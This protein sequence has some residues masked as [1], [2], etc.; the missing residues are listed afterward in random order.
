MANVGDVTGDLDDRVSVRLG[1]LAPG[2]DAFD[3]PILESY[4]VTRS[5]LT[6]P[7]TFS[8]R[9]GWGD[10]AR[11]LL[12]VLPPRLPFQLVVNGA[13]Q[14]TGTLDGYEASDGG[15]ATEITIRGRDVMAPLHDAFIRAELSLQDITYAQL[16]EKALDATV[17]AH[18]LFYTNEDN[19]K[20]TTGIG[21]RQ[22]GAPQTDPTQSSKGPTAKQLKAHIG[23]R[24]YEYLK[25]Q[26]D[27]AGLFLWAGGLGEFILSEPNAAQAPA[28]Q[29]VRR[30]GQ[31]RNAVNVIRASYRNDT[32][33]R[34]S[35]CIVHGRGGG[36]KFGRSKIAGSYTD[37]EMVAWGFD[38]PLV[39][40]DV[41]VT[42]EEQAAFYARRKLAEARRAGWSLT[43][44][45]AG[46]TVPSLLGGERA[47]WA[48][49]TVVAVDDGEYGIQGNYYIERV[50]FRRGPETTTELT[51]QRPED[52]V[53]AIV[54]GE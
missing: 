39:A 20:L 29:I 19:R 49:D 30:R 31:E 1:P 16:A 38:R 37:Q 46:H 48:P 9:F 3:A 13:V 18:T 10:V 26:L 2:G 54:E 33:Q 41:Q 22:T 17:G 8:A 5:L 6:Q 27:R 52:L 21:V 24:W 12:D 35:E 44:L 42:N 40:R 28:Y 53:F 4:E 23:D 7:T 51:L 45:V 11:D 32:V 34:Y 15:G 50:V 36:R 47:V 14:M 43:Y 25:R